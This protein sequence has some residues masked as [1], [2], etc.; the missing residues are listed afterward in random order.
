MWILSTQYHGPSY[1]HCKT[2]SFLQENIAGIKHSLMQSLKN[3]FKSQDW[4]CIIY[5]QCPFFQPNDY[6]HFLS[7]TS[8]DK[9]ST[10]NR[11]R[12]SKKTHNYFM[13]LNLRFFFLKG[14]LWNNQEHN[15]YWTNYL[16]V[17]KLL[18]STG[19]NI[20]SLRRDYLHNTWPHKDF[21]HFLSG[22]CTEK[23]I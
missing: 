5:R 14:S 18:R 16:V 6:V 20:D 1:C 10:V 8:C 4:R 15:L 7:F 9:F 13:F 12:I 23:Y 17:S 22:L 2:R 3:H 11:K 19:R 21:Q